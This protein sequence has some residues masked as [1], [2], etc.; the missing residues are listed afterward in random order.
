MVPGYKQRI[1][2]FRAVYVEVSFLMRILDLYIAHCIISIQFFTL[3]MIGS[4]STKQKVALT[5]ILTG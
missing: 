1:N 2:H 5:H 3:F 4:I